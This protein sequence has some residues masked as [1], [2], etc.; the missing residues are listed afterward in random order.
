MTNNTENFAAGQAVLAEC[1]TAMEAD[2]LSIGAVAREIG[3]GCSAATL[4][5]WLSG[6]YTGDV[7][8][9][10]ARV[11]RWLDT[12]AEL[13]AHDLSAAGLNLTRHV[14]FQATARVPAAL[15][16]AQAEGDIVCIHGRSGA[17]KTM[18]LLHYA[19]TRISTFY[20]AMTGAVRSLA[21][22]LDR[23]AAAVGAGDVHRSALAAETAIV[24]QLTGRQ[25]LLI[26]DEAHHLSPAQLDELRCIRDIAGCGLALAGHDTLWM[27]LA[28][29][30]RCDQIVGRIAWRLP[31]APPADDDVLA[32]AEGI[33]DFRP[34]GDAAAAVLAA[35]RSPGGLHAVRRVFV[36]ALAIARADGRATLRAADI[37]AA[38]SAAGV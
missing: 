32:L 24:R 6:Q 30:R 10:T 2:G 12:R 8:A 1:R 34:E 21:G 25:A 7:A 23:V 19:E 5:Q 15:A 29:S 38:R 20:L 27:T 14:P 17:G 28:G 18:A 36:L 13:A 11:R 35:V 31:L 26:V 33:L 3:R 37:A 9:V 4:S 16:V 22:M